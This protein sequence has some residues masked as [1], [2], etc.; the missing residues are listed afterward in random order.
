MDT[1]PPTQY[2]FYY[3]LYLELSLDYIKPSPEAWDWRWLV[4]MMMT[5][6]LPA[7]DQELNIKLKVGIIDIRLGGYVTMIQLRLDQLCILHH[8]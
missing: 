6:L 2:L 3:S 1:Y 7:C 4:T 5:V 8:Y